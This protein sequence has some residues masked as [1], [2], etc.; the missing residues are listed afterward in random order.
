MR[1]VGAV[2]LWS[3]ERSLRDRAK[4]SL[5]GVAVGV[6]VVGAIAAFALTG[7]DRAWTKFHEIAFRNDL[8]SL[9]PSRD[10]LIQMFPEPFWE[11]MTFLVAALTFAEVLL[12]VIT[13]TVYLF[14]KPKSAGQSGAG[15]PELLHSRRAG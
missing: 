11:E 9:D 13:A 4:Y 10:R 12:L 15:E 3:R 14:L 2:V 1:Y 5:M 6:V 7:F 8:W